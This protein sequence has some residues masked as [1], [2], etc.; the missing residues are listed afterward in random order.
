MGTNKQETRRAATLEEY[1]PWPHVRLAETDRLETF[2]D[3]VLSITMTLLVFE[4]VRPEY[5][6]GQLLEKLVAQWASYIGFLA[7]FCYA[8]VIW[9]NHRAVFAR[10]RYCDRSLHLANLF[11]LLT[12]ALIP[13]P[14]AILSTAIQSGNEFDAKVAVTLYAAIAGTMC[15]SWLVVFH[16]LSIH[17]YLL[18]DGVNP[19]FFPKER[20]RATLGVILY[21][22]AGAAGCLSTPKVALLIFLALPVFYGI[23]SEGLTETRIRLQFGKAHRGALAKSG[24]LAKSSHEALRTE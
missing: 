3:S 10:V 15:L 1:S 11:L 2:S 8:G 12:S 18:E 14:T 4:I 5:A 21:A 6:S 19:D 20:F 24:V 16:V 22:I 17:P 7:S 9:L 23:T 13:F